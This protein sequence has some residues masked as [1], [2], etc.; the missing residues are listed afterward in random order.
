MNVPKEGLLDIE[1]VLFVVN[2]G[3]GTMALSPKWIIVS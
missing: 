2:L 3:Y 1:R